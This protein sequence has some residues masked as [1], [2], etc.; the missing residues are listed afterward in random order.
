MPSLRRLAR[1]DCDR[2]KCVDALLGGGCGLVVEPSLDIARAADRFRRGGPDICDVMIRF[3]A[4][5]AGA[6]PLYTFDREAAPL[7]G[8]TLLSDRQAS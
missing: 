5:R 6:E 8:V 7:D 2:N 1:N 4:E 3:A